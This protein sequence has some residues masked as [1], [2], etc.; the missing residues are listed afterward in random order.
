MLN[1]HVRILAL[2][3]TLL[4]AAAASGVWRAPLE[5]QPESRLWIAGTSTVRSFRCTATSFDAKVE[6]PAASA[7]A[8]V[9]AGE[10]SVG[11]I[12]L[13]IPAD[14]LDCRNGTMNEH[15]L[16]ALK[17]T[18]FPVITFR[19]SSYDLVRGDEGMQVQMNGTLTLGGVEKTITVQAQ[20]KAGEGGK[21]HVAGTYALKMTDYG[22]KAPKLML[23]T[24]RVNENVTVGFDI[25]LKDRAE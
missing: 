16:K 21:L 22:L 25:V 15:M 2:C 6:S 14:S 3:A 24:M 12:A 23:G 10:K 17:A 11:A 8:S 5:L 13:S 19:T 1:T 9:L 18:S 4:P 20:A 7:V